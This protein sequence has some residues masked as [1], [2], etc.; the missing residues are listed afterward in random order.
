MGKFIITEDEKKY[1]MGLYEQ[2][3]DKIDISSPSEDR[4]PKFNIPELKSLHEVLVDMGFK[5]ESKAGYSMNMVYKDKEPRADVYGVVM[6]KE[7]GTSW[8]IL[9]DVSRFKIDGMS[10]GVYNTDVSQFH[11][12]NFNIKKN[13][14]SKSNGANWEMIENNKMYRIEINNISNEQSVKEICRHITQ[15]D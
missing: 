3:I 10:N 4:G 13:I 2:F 5:D 9:I 6:Q 11:Q 7:E 14:E 15:F 8:N 12:N 1:I